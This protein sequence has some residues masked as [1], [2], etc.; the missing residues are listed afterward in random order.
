VSDRQRKIT[1]RHRARHAAAVAGTG[2][3]RPHVVRA[4]HLAGIAGAWA[5][6]LSLVLA[7]VVLVAGIGPRSAT[8][9]VK[10]VGRQTQMHAP[11]RARR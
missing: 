10:N 9:H 3:L 4:L 8:A 2:S 5:V 6:G 11:R 1:L 7:A